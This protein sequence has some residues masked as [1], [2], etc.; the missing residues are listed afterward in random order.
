MGYLG[1]GTNARVQK[2]IYNGQ[3]VAVKIFNKKNDSNSETEYLKEVR[4]SRVFFYFYRIK[5]Y[6]KKFLLNRIFRRNKHIPYYFIVKKLSFRKLVY[7]EV[8]KHDQLCTY[9]VSI[10]GTAFTSS[11]YGRSKNEL[12]YSPGARLHESRLRIPIRGVPHRHT[13]NSLL[14]LF[15][16]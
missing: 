8:R 13:V 7:S 4:I 6:K 11:D 9:T 15:T 10:F 3:I 2:A 1:S 14:E 12:F 5:P 16:S